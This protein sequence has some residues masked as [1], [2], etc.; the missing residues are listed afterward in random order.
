M[1][2]N[3]A[4]LRAAFEEFASFGASRTTLRS[5]GPAP[6]HAA[7]VLMDSSKF[8]K[9][10]RDSGLIDNESLTLT[11]VDIVFAKC[12]KKGAR[13]LDYEDF[14]KA[15]V[16]VADTRQVAIEH[17]VLM[18]TATAPEINGTLPEHDELV[19]KLTDVSLYT[20]T[21]RARFDPVTGQGLGLDGR[22]PVSPTADLSAIVSRHNSAKTLGNKLARAKSPTP[23]TAGS[24]QAAGPSVF[25]RLNHVSTFTGTHKHRFNEDGTGRGKAGRD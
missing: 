21:H 22:E 11:D 17:V 12:K 16:E 14:K 10:M 13:K 19:Q 5:P 23:A 7:P 15:L 24:E 4:E 8:A 1:L 9:L 3:N 25:D 2:R 18:I 20:G 6:H